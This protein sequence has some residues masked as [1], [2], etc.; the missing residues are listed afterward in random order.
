[1]LRAGRVV[2]GQLVAVAEQRAAELAESPLAPVRFVLAN[3]TILMNWNVNSSLVLASVWPI[4][5]L[6]LRAGQGQP[7]SEGQHRHPHHETPFS[8]SRSVTHRYCWNG[9]LD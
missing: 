5:I 6:Q 7:F 8:F 2:A 9:R 4:L 3:L 1:M